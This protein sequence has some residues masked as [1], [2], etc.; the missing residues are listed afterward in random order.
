MLLGGVCIDDADRLRAGSAQAVLP[1]VVAAPSTSGSF[2]R[3]FRLGHVRQF[4]K[5]QEQALAR[6]WSLGAAPLPAGGLT[7]DLDSTVCQVCGKAKQGAAYGYSKVLCY[8]PLVA[9]RADS[10][11]ILHCRMRK[12]SSQRGHQRFAAETLGRVRRAAQR[13]DMKL[14]VRAASGF[15]SYEML[16]TLARHD[17]SYSIT[18]PQLPHIKAAI[19]TINDKAWQPIAYTRGGEAQVAE[20]TF[21]T[22]DRSRSDKPRTLRLAMRRTRITG[23]QGELWRRWRHHAFI[24]NRSDLQIRPRHQNR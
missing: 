16:D 6:A 14:C 22:S 1:F 5:A 18:A 23:P 10:G 19:K 20:T 17:A 9:T 15:F 12:G 3:S 13:R 4:D 2:L 24:T 7:V 8:H 21:T 11:E